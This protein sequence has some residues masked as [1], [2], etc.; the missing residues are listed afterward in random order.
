MRLRSCGDA[1]DSRGDHALCCRCGVGKH[2]RHSEVNAR[3]KRALADAGIATTLEPVGLDVANGKRPDGLTILSFTRGREM[4]WDATISH[5]CAPTYFRKCCHSTCRCR[6]CRRK[7]SA[8]VRVHRWPCRLSCSGPRNFR[9]FRP[10]RSRSPGLKCSMNPGTVRI[11]WRTR[12]ALSTDLRRS[13]DR[14]RGLHFGG[15]FPAPLTYNT[16]L[17]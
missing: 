5:T 14:K 12:A 2:A 3:I 7:E 4:A 9:R 17:I 8:Q 6:A 10:Q 11:C 13:T 1:L 16:L 15:A